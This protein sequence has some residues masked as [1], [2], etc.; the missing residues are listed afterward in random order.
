MAPLTLAQIGIS[1]VVDLDVPVLNFSQ[2][3]LAIQTEHPLTMGAIYQFRLSHEEKSVTLD[4]EVVRCNLTELAETVTGEPV[5]LYLNGIRFMI[6]RNPIELSML[7]IMTGHMGR[8]NRAAPRIKPR[9]KMLVDIGRPCFSQILAITMGSALLECSELLDM[10]QDWNLMIQ[11]EGRNVII[12][13]RVQHASKK[14]NA[15]SFEI[16]VEFYKPDKQALIFL[17]DLAKRLV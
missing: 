3:G 6:E 11:V 12:P 14:N 7:D 13:A 9:Q 16:N 10:D 15:D 8:E 4:G 17:E 1:I 5:T 2:S